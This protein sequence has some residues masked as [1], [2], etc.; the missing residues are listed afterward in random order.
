MPE[1]AAQ[2]K[3]LAEFMKVEFFD[4]GSVFRPTV[5]ETTGI[6]IA[7]ARAGCDVGNV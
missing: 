3:A 1:L 6:L 4:A 2:Y 7:F 5:M